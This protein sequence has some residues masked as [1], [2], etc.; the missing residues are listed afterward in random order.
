MSLSWHKGIVDDRLIDR[1]IGSVRDSRR[2]MDGCME[3][4]TKEEEEGMQRGG[5]KIG[6]SR[7][8]WDN[9]KQKRGGAK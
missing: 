9:K 2:C 1:D 6:G 4:D 8:D 3:N 7:E 5:L